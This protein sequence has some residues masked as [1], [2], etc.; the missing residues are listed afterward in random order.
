MTK[1]GNQKN[2]PAAQP[3]PYS[4]CPCA[5]RPVRFETLKALEDAGTLLLRSG[6]PLCDRDGGGNVCLSLSL[7]SP[8]PRPLNRKA[9]HELR[10]AA[11]AGML[12]GAPRFGLEL[13][14]LQTSGV[15]SCEYGRFAVPLV[16][17]PEFPDIEED[18]VA[19]IFRTPDG[20]LEPGLGNESLSGYS[21]SPDE[22][23]PVGLARSPEAEDPLSRLRAR[24]L[25]RDWLEAWCGRFYLLRW[26]T[27][28]CGKSGYSA[29]L[30][31]GSAAELE[32]RAMP[33]LEW[34]GYDRP[35]AVAALT[36]A[37]E[38]EEAY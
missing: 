31:A 9:L 13:S 37:K 16:R 10:D 1:S 18:F 11:L 14:F 30:S 12:W 21:R 24:A 6:A 19:V 22:F 29:L 8:V 2:V 7:L 34:T 5:W 28:H 15:P 33:Y 36:A 38:G 26:W 20:G 32:R 3:L 23:R 25:A 35:F 17:V 27:P 4:G